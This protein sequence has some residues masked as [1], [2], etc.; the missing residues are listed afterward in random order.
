MSAWAHFYPNCV[1]INHELKYAVPDRWLR[2]HYTPASQQGA[3]SADEVAAAL[4]V[5][6]TA[7]TAVL[8]NGL[9]CWVSGPLYSSNDMAYA[10][11]LAVLR[12]LNMPKAGHLKLPNDEG[13][14]DIY[15]A[16][17]SWIPNHFNDILRKIE[18]DEVHV[19]W[20]CAATGAVFAPYD[21][22]VDLI[23]PTTTDVS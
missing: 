9:A 7:A 4:H 21:R 10:D 2:F 15:A 14:L 13:H 1:P 18:N 22:G 20:M 12:Q 8:G 16:L 3:S 19:M 23:L 11:Q 6:N 17:V 5:M